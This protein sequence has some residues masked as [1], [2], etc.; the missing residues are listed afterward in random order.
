MTARAVRSPRAISANPSMA[1]SRAPV[2]SCAN[3]T[4][5]TAVMAMKSASQMVRTHGVWVS[6]GA[7]SRLEVSARA[8]RHTVATAIAASTMPV[9][10]PSITPPVATS[11]MRLAMAVFSTPPAVHADA[12]PTTHKPTTRSH[13]AA[14]WWPV[15]FRAKAARLTQTIAAIRVRKR[16]AYAGSVAVRSRRAPRLATRTVRASQ[17]IRRAVLACCGSA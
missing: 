4:M 17:W 12:D 10:H 7:G 3:S 14:A 8:M 5:A 9:L 2:R 6:A 13:A 11:T 1:L 15:L 16:S